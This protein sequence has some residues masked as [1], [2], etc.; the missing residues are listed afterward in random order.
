MEAERIAE[1][2]NKIKTRKEELDNL[3][4]TYAK[5]TKEKN[6]YLDME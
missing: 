1:V 5:L 3:D 4:E 2:E 6:Q